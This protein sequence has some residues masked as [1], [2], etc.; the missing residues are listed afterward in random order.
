MKKRII[1]S[2]LQHEQNALQ[3]IALF[4]PAFRAA[5]PLGRPT[6]VVVSLGIYAFF[7]GVARPWQTPVADIGLFVASWV[8]GVLCGIP[9]ALVVVSYV[10]EV[11]FKAWDILVHLARGELRFKPILILAPAIAVALVAVGLY[12]LTVPDAE[13]YGAAGILMAPILLRFFVTGFWDWMQLAKEVDE[14]EA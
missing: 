6:I 8:G 13:R 9:V 10:I 7:L 1:D 12:L 4:D 2:Q 11:I 3:R 14:E 5:F